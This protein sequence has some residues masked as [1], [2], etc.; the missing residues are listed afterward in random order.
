M[1]IS[2]GMHQCHHL[3]NADTPFTLIQFALDELP[4]TVS[5]INIFASSSHL[6]ASSSFNLNYPKSSNTTN[7]N[8]SNHNT[9][10]SSQYADLTK[11]FAVVSTLIRCFDL[12]PYT[13]SSVQGQVSEIN[14][15]FF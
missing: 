8:T 5:N 7:I 15:Y 3:I 6:S 2:I 10:S 9:P 12:S 13:A 4:T 14:F 11:L 1:Y